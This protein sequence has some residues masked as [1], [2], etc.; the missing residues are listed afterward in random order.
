MKVHSSQA[1]GRKGEP[2]VLMTRSNVEN[3]V[4]YSNMDLVVF[5]W[6]QLLYISLN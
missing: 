1:P 5:H 4:Q 2:E 3:R 6:L